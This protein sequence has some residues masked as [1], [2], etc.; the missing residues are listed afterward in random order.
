MKI[1]LKVDAAYRTSLLMHKKYRT[2]DTV[3]LFH[4]AQQ[5]VLGRLPITSREMAIAVLLSRDQ[6]QAR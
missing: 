3:E 6:Y 4:E 1:V 2:H 5:Y